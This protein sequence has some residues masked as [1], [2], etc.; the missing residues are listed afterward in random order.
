[1][2][3]INED[4]NLIFATEFEDNLPLVE[5]RYSEDGVCLEN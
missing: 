4:F 2:I 5:F 1:M 3:N